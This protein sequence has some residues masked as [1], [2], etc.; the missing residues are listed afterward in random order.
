MELTLKIS[1]GLEHFIGP[2][3][4]TPA[5]LMEKTI[6]GSGGGR[7]WRLQS[8]CPGGERGVVSLG[9]LLR[10]SPLNTLPKTIIWGLFLSQLFSPGPPPL[11]WAPPQ[12]NLLPDLYS[13]SSVRHSLHRYWFIPS[14]WAYWALL[15]WAIALGK[16]KVNQKW[17]TMCE[18]LETGMNKAPSFSSSEKV[19]RP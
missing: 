1:S 13:A 12:L 11:H 2:W 4:F 17:F 10:S 9:H 7:Q 6:Q 3:K 14:A 8:C 18:A 19:D 15:V 16:R 5:R